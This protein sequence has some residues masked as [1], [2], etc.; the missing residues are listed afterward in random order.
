M[1]ILIFCYQNI[2][3]CCVVYTNCKKISKITTDLI[4]N[5]D[6]HL[7]FNQCIYDLTIHYIKIVLGITMNT[8]LLRMSLFL[9]G[10]TPAYTI[11]FKNMLI[12]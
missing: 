8:R 5:N 1:L 2:N 7:F 9:T 4:Q 11:Y 3:I 12:A 10:Y 6:L